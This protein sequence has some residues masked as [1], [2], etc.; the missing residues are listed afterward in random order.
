MV[1]SEVEIG[2][3]VV[4][5]RKSEGTSLE[6]SI[7]WR[8]AKALNQG[9]L[10]VVR[11]FGGGD[12]VL[13]EK[14]DRSSGDIFNADDFELYAASPKKKEVD[15]AVKEIWV[16]AYLV[17]MGSAECAYPCPETAADKLV[18]EYLKRFE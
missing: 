3:R 2:M 8:R 17:A 7:V 9:Y 11:D 15:P 13:H 6:N 12:F 10:Y 5:L 4:P 1:A 14:E 16:K 18:E